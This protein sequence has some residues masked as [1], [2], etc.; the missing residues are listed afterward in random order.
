MQVYPLTSPIILTDGIFNDFG[1]RPGSSSPKQ[2]SYAYMMSEEQVSAYIGTLL[3]PVIVTGTY[4]YGNS[5][6]VSTDYGYV[7]R[8]LGVNVL[9]Q[10]VFPNSCD[11]I[12]NPGCAFIQSDTFGYVD[13][14][15]VLGACG[16]YLP[17]SSFYGYYPPYRGIT[18]QFQIA[19][20]AGLPTGTANLPGVLQALS[21]VAQINLNEMVGDGSAGINEGVGDVG[22]QSF[23]TLD[24]SERRVPL[25]HTAL[26]NSARAKRAAMLLDS[27]IR[28]ARKSL[29]I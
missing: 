29:V 5:P 16:L 25:G 17:P 19:Y 4:N 6:R 18:Y 13:V 23:H 24:Y 14:H 20:E 2:R 8:I 28:K 7:S 26:G 9:S 10:N 12:S 21:I 1:G 27:S 11:L 3:L 15:Q 22:I